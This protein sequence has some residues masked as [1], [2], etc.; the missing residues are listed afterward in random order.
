[1]TYSPSEQFSH[2]SKWLEACQHESDDQPLNLIPQTNSA[3]KTFGEAGDPL[4]NNG[5]KTGVCVPSPGGLQQDITLE[6][7]LDTMAATNSFPPD[8]PLRPG[9]LLRQGLAACVEDSLAVVPAM[10]EK[11]TFQNPLSHLL[12]YP[13]NPCSEQHLHCSKESP[14]DSRTEAVPEDLVSSDRNA[15]L[16]SFMLCLSPSPALAADFPVSHV[17]PGEDTV[18]HRAVEEREMSFPAL[19]EEAELGDQALVSNVE[20]IPSSCLTLNPGEMESQ[21]APGPAVE[22]A[23]RILISDTGPWMSPLTWLEKGVNTSVMLENLRQSLSLPSVLRD[24]AT[25]TTPLSTC[26]VGTWLTPP[27]PQEKSSNTSQA[28][29]EGTKDGT[30]ERE[31]L[32]WG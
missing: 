27:A 12:E 25:G 28:G 29:L 17:D 7:P 13:P 24:A 14:R 2:P 22:D 18:E 20:D 10:P 9:D 15:F 23:G 1:M 19:I 21:A 8:E 26:S 31:H 5:I 6:A 30:S 3:P 11:P 16:H 4:D 32:L